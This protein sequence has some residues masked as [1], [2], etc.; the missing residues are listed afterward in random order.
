MLIKNK[1]GVTM[2]SWTEGILFSLLIVLILGIVVGG[3]N[4]MYGE[5]NQLGLG[6]NT[7]ESAF[8]DYQGT[9][10]SEIRGGEAEFDSTSGMTLKSS[11][12]IIKSATGIIW[13][14]LTGGWIET[15]VMYMKLPSEVALVFRILYF[16]SIGFII[17]KILFKVKP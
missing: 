2:S 6:G 14:F 4:V 1:K 5:D 8:A 15:I 12:G 16:L 10:E 17:L 11:W 7:T 13:D 3:F 9:L